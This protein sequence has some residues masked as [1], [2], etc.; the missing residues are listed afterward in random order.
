[1]VSNQEAEPLEVSRAVGSTPNGWEDRSVIFFANLLSLF[2]GNRGGA[3][4]L[5]Q[6]IR[7]VDSYGGR[8]LPVLGLIFGGSN[9]V[10]VLERQPEP[11]LRQL[12]LDIGLDLPKTEI[13]TRHE[14]L[15]LGSKLDQG[16]LAGQPLLDRLREEPAGYLDGFVTDETIE[17]IA[18]ELGKRTLSTLEGSHRGNNKLLLHQHLESR[19][20]PVFPTILAARAEEVPN[21][22]RALSK[23]GYR[24]GV[25]K[26][27]IGASGIGLIKAST[28]G[29]A[30][31]VPPAFF[32][33]G[34]CMVQAWLEPGT[35]GVRSVLSPSVQMFLSR[36]T[37]LLYDLTEQ[38]LDPEASIHQGNE[39]PPGYLDVHPG[40][41][42]ELFHQA[43]E[44]ARWL[45]RQ[46]YR[47]A[48]STDFLV[49]LWEDGDA[50]SYICEINARVTGATYPSVLA[51]H[52]QPQGSWRMRNLELSQPMHGADLL[53]R[54]KQRGELFDPTSRR[55]ILPVNFNLDPEGRVRKGQ[56]LAIGERLDDCRH[57][58]DAARHDL[59]VRWDY[60]HDR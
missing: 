49:T 57:L 17:R 53:D 30:V 45:H 32:H 47:G 26:A 59:P 3:R 28:D 41:A 18:T 22:L 52:F 42:D 35:H 14:F 19:G 31:E 54:L 6:E 34:P 8:L 1:M 39:S 60:T 25:I 56:F 38:I 37:A 40:L 51:R 23:Q 33:E 46:G 44:A 58:L 7:C 4:Q 43:A 50:T 21:A 13:L 36:D 15:E 55:G 27:Q 2:F 12:F 24:H 9:N 20:L 10:L 29:A 48:A 16:R 5:E 11:S